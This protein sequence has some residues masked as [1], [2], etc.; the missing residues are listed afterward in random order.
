MK[1]MRRGLIQ[2]IRKLITVFSTDVEM[3]QAVLELLTIEEL[4]S[5]SPTEDI[6]KEPQVMP[7]ESLS[8]V[9][10]PR[11]GS[12][13][14]SCIAS[15]DDVEVRDRMLGSTDIQIQRSHASSPTSSLTDCLIA[16]LRLKAEASRWARQRAMRRRNRV[17]NQIEIEL[18]HREFVDRAR[19]IGGG[20]Y[21]WMCHHLFHP[22]EDLNCLVQL[23]EW[24]DAC[25]DVVAL[26]SE[27]F[28]NEE[29]A[30]LPLRQAL[31]LIAES[32]SGLRVAIRHVTTIDD[33]DQRELFCRVRSKCD[34]ERI[35]LERYMRVDDVPELGSV[36]ALRIRARQLTEQFDER[37]SQDV[38]QRKLFGKL[39]Y[40]IK[41]NCNRPSS[42]SQVD[43]QTIAETV[44][45]LV[46][47]GV[48][49][50]NLKLRDLLMPVLDLV[51]N[52]SE[53]PAGFRLALRSTGIS[54]VPFSDTEEEGSE[55]ECVQKVSALLRDRSIVLIGGDCRPDRKAIIERAFQ[56][57]ELIWVETTHGTSP[58]DTESHIARPDAALVVLAIRWVSHGL[59]DVRRYCELYDKPLVRL[60]GGYGVNQLAFQ[61][62]SQCG[63][64]LH[65]TDAA[66]N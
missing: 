47:V 30:F 5:S 20:C 44:D 36:A 31:S 16:R 52:T 3:R 13:Q 45:G 57:R 25:G 59:S 17:D 9:E 55:T 15:S 26:T 24:F 53:W 22:P 11:D 18:S 10:A 60:P 37:R 21:L 46:K 8:G 63:D 2:L 58:S 33:P 66:S 12:P 27:L 29:P 50:S 4:T 1:P 6:S 41:T 7:V 48:P 32:Q 49:P 51:P 23:A 35:Y 54:T 43:W 38:K 39:D 64:R 62:Y 34:E 42:D 56:L 40:L 19:I 65:S 28:G 14:T 61:I